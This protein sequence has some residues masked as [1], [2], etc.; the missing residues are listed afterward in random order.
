MFKQFIEL[1]NKSN[2]LTQSAQP[3][4][5]VYQELLHAQKNNSIPT[6]GNLGNFQN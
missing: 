2:L 4:L 1:K 3:N 5:S 6:D